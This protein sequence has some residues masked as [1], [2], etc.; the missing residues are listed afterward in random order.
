MY[1]I[2]A[3]YASYYDAAMS[4][5]NYKGGLFANVTDPTAFGKIASSNGY[6]I[7]VSTFVSIANTLA[8]CLH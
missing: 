1:A 3:G 2:M 4:F 6:G 5:V 8:T 7:S